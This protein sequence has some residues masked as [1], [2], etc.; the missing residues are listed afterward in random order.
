MM[1]GYE[2]RIWWF[3]TVD[4]A[5]SLPIK[6]AFSALKTLLVVILKTVLY[7]K[8]ISS[9]H[10]FIRARHCRI[11]VVSSAFS[12]IFIQI[13]SICSSVYHCL[14]TMS[15]TIDLLVNYLC[16]I[17]C[18]L[19]FM[20]G[21]DLLSTHSLITKI[22]QLVQSSS[23]CTVPINFIVDLFIYKSVQVVCCYHSSVY[24]AHER[25]LFLLL[26]KGLKYENKI[27]NMSPVFT[28][29]DP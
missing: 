25:L 19:C 27:I 2:D 4:M 15:N 8:S 7:S 21:I 16:F 24:M 14:I 5:S 11:V 29:F 23:A 20:L 17:K 18:L 1:Y 13:L 12:C 6:E 10:L 22:I 28:C 3:Y 9:Q 26:F